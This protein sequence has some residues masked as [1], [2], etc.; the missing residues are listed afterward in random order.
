M[1][2]I[3]A[4]CAGLNRN[5]L[6]ASRRSEIIG[7]LSGQNS[8]GNLH[9]IC[10]TEWLSYVVERVRVPASGLKVQDA[11]DCPRAGR[12]A[13]ETVTAKALAGVHQV[14]LGQRTAVIIASAAVRE[15]GM[16]MPV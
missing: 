3:S 1:T 7:V 10:H 14:E 12:A 16:Q 8:G 5:R 4:L 6:Q 13:A 15:R 9:D 2:I 11:R